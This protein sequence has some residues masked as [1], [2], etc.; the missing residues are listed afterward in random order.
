M[1]QNFY[2]LL[3]LNTWAIS[4]I[5]NAANKLLKIYAGDS[6]NDF[7]LEAVI[8]EKELLNQNFSNV[9]LTLRIYLTLP[10]ANTEG[11]RSFSALKIE[12]QSAL[13]SDA[14]LRL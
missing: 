3:S 12:Q 4:N 8:F 10:V 13:I 2:F 7:P 11:E 1:R 5:E 9:A 6:D 14:E